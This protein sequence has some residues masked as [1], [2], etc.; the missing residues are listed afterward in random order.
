MQKGECH[1]KW[2]T[3]PESISRML[4]NLGI[5]TN[6]MET[7]QLDTIKSQVTGDYMILKNTEE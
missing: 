5:L 1:I 3:L 4:H 6:H 2:Y 7:S